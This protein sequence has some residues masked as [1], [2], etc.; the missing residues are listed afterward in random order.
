M[1]VSDYGKK[2]DLNSR[3]LHFVL[4]CVLFMTVSYLFRN[5]R[6]VYQLKRDNVFH[7]RKKPITSLLVSG[8]GG[9]VGGGATERTSNFIPKGE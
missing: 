1:C 7:L 6:R 4:Y 8:G 5:F 9:G 3:T 2:S